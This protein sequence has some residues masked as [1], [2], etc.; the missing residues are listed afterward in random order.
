MSAAFPLEI[1]FVRKIMIALPSY[2]AQP[3]WRCAESIRATVEAGPAHGIEWQPVGALGV[4]V[5]PRVR[6]Y[7]CARMLSDPAFEGL[8]FVDDDIGF[9]PDYA[10]RI[11]SH[12]E[13]VVAGVAQKR[14]NQWNGPPELNCAIEPF[15]PVDGRLLV[16]NTF[17]PTCFM[18]IARSALITILEN[19]QLYDTGMVRHFI[20]GGLTDDDP[21]HP[22]M[23]T[24]F[25]YGLASVREGSREEKIAAQWGVEDPCVDIGEDYDFTIKCE[26]AGIPVFLDA[27]VELQHY[28]GRTCYDWSLKKALAA[29][30]ARIGPDPRAEAA[31]GEGSATLEE[32][33]ETA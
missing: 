7:L 5:L 10:A 19:R 4:G 20:Y 15:A 21:A 2:S 13:Q 1:C 14:M 24:F 31:P 32:K 25:S 18:W 11:V 16:R 23:A 12:G 33:K 3:H 17:A 29:G 26:V 30:S 8:L 9:H 27:E 22:W 28:D 6:N